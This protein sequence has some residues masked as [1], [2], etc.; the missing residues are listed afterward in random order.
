MPLMTPTNT[1]WLRIRELWGSVFWP[2]PS[3]FT[4]WRDQRRAIVQC[5]L[6]LLVLLILLC[7]VG[8]VLDAPLARLMRSLPSSLI[9]IFDRITRI[10]T[11]GWVLFLSGLVTLIAPLTIAPYQRR[12]VQAGLQVLAERAAY[13]FLVLVLS[14]LMS[15]LIKHGLGRA[16]PK[17]MDQLGAFH[18]DLFVWDASYASF[19]SGHTI[20]AFAVASSLALFLPRYA[21]IVWAVALLVGMSRLALGAHFLTDVLGGAMI[22][23]A[24]AHALGYVLARRRLVFTRYLIPRGQRAI[25]AA[26]VYFIEIR[27]YT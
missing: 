11:S 2:L 9:S 23:I 27:R 16:R 1:Y 13:V 15:I 5:A 26:L 24:S 12:R 17:L 10:G 8:L 14:G 3:F 22:G 7:I 19:P 20:T 25:L 4:L 18:F 21:R 6:A